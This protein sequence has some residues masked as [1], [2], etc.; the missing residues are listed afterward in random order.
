MNR[1]RILRPSDLEQLLLL[2][3]D[4]VV[5]QAVRLY[6]PAQIAAWVEHASRSNGVAIA[7][8]QGYGLGSHPVDQPNE[9]EAFGILEP[10]DRLSLLYCRG[11]ASRR[12]LAS[13][14]LEKL[15]AHARRH[16]VSQ[17]RT[18]ASQ[19]SR[20]LLLRRGWQVEAAE[21]VQLQG[22]SFERWRMI[23]PLT[24]AHLGA[25]AARG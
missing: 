7:L 10:A 11:V 23:K 6:S 8:Q 4:A 18:E 3:R 22:V 25:A 17:L 19:L 9:L 16:G 12:G 2:Y 1:L 20:P 13:T 24:T 21:T 5:S 14:I 15:E